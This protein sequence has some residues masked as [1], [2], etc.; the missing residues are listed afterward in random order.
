MILCPFLFVIF[1][2]CLML[3]RNNES[4]KNSSDLNSYATMICHLFSAYGMTTKGGVGHS[5]W[6]IR[7]SGMPLTHKSQHISPSLPQCGWP[8]NSIWW[9]SLRQHPVLTSNALKQPWL[10]FIL[11]TPASWY[12]DTGTWNPPYSLCSAMA[13]RTSRPYQRTG[14][15]N[16]NGTH[17]ALS[18]V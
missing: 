5:T 7:C 9:K 18:T 16:T 14:T 2:L 1:S 13:Q 17:L 6:H 12:L 4:F 3:Q 10:T 15:R 8:V 11:R